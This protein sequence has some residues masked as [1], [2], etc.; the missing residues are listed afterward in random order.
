MKDLNDHIQSFESGTKLIP[1]SEKIK[2]VVMTFDD[3][4]LCEIYWNTA[5]FKE[6]MN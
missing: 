3:L 6:K 1:S 4:K 5:Q 2:K